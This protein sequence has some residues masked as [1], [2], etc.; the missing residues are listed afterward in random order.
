MDYVYSTTTRE[1]GS[2]FTYQDRQSLE[3]MVIENH[4][5]AV[6]RKISQIE[7][8]ERLGVHRSTI[9]WGTL[10]SQRFSRRFP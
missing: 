9:S 6:K 10:L 3:K 5:R 7:M 2:H 1:K 8:K 4:R